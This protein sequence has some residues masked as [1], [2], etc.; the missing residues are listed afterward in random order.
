M[1]FR[2]RYSEA[3]EK[4][5][6]NISNVGLTHML[7]KWSGLPSRRVSDIKLHINGDLE[8]F[9]TVFS[10][11]TR[12]AKSDMQSG[13]SHH[14]VDEPEYQDDSSYSLNFYEDYDINDWIEWT[15]DDE[16]GLYYRE[17]LL[18][19]G[20]LSCGAY[21]E[22][23]NWWE[24]EQIEEFLDEWDLQE[25]YQLSGFR[26]RY[27]YGGYRRRKGKGKSKGR[28]KGKGRGKG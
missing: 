2:E 28:D 24:A 17:Y 1:N 19:S 6:L 11:L 21:D 15:H 26:P 4:A 22:S 5:G 16:T 14:Y 13:S 12:I 7:F 3:A 27:R 20:E 25:A 10:M 23:G 8:Q 18:D 9:Q